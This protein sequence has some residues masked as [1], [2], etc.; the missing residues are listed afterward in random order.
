MA[1]PW[2]AIETMVEPQAQARL[3]ARARDRVREGNPPPRVLR[4]V[5]LESWERSAQAGVYAEPAALPP[6]LS[7]EEL[8]ERRAG[9]PLLDAMPLIRS[10]LVDAA[11]DARHIVAVCDATGHLLWVEGNRA[12][13][14]AGVEIGFVAGSDWSERTAGTNAPGT[15]LEADHPIQVFAGEHYNEGIAQWTCAAAPVHDPDSGALLGAVDLTGAYDTAHPSALALANAAARAAEAHLAARHAAR[16]AL[17]VETARGRAAAGAGVTVVSP[18]GRLLGADLGQ[19][20]IA[21]PTAPGRLR[22]GRVVVEAE[23]LTGAPGY[24]VLHRDRTRDHGGRGRAADAARPSGSAVTPS[25]AGTAASGPGAVPPGDAAASP[26]GPVELRLLGGSG[27]ALLLA[28]EQLAVTPRQLEVCALL[29]LHPDGLTSDEL[30]ELLYGEQEVAEVT[31][32]AELSRLRRRLG[33]ALSAR[34][35]RFSV[36]VTTDVEQVERLLHAGD[37][38]GAVQAYTGPLVPYSESPFL[39][40]RRDQLHY[41]LRA[42]LLAGEDADALTAW[43]RAPH[44][45]RDGAAARRLTGLVAPTDPR[46]ATAVAVVETSLFARG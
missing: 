20:R 46:H 23:Q 18:G 15:A 30:R 36:P 31:I 33:G 44:G 1:N 42:A 11:D 8:E 10:L 14:R 22:I 13:R 9:H 39:N 12:T 7:D 16:D 2:L 6:L 32:R 3:I 35:Y 17:A 25:P 5:V 24:W 38:R 21:P 40:E 37:L 4:P 43:L 19:Q 27:A 34:P 29:A 41:E 26:C 45:A 28:G